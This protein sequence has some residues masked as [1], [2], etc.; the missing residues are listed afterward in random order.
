M[1]A[2]IKYCT[3]LDTRAADPIE[4]GRRPGIRGGSKQPKFLVEDLH[5]IDDYEF[6]KKMTPHQLNA[7]VKS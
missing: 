7:C 5:K 4:L 3:K 2:C 1:T 6:A